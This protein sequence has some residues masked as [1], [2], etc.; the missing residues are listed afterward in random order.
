MR[1]K[2]SITVAGGGV[3]G[4]ACAA[5]LAQR[6]IPVLLITT[7][8]VQSLSSEEGYDA[9][10]YAL[11]LNSLALLEEIEVMPLVTRYTDF[12]ALEVWDAQSSGH[13]RF[14]AADIGS[15]RLGI[16]IEHRQLLSALQQRLKQLKIEPIGAQLKSATVSK[17]GSCVSL[18]LDNGQQLDTSL[19]IGADGFNSSV[20]TLMN[21][22]WQVQ[23]YRQTAFSCAAY[24]TTDHQMTGWQQFS[25]HGVVAFLPLAE[26]A[27]TIVWSCPA[28]L[29]SE[30]KLLAPP[31]LLQRV[32]SEISKHFENLSL[33]SPVAS[34]PLRGGQVDQYTKPGMVLIGD[35]AHSVHPLAGQGANLGFTDLSVLLNILDHSRLDYFNAAML[36]R[37]QRTVKGTNHLMKSGLEMLLW[38]FAND[39]A[40]SVSYVL[41]RV[42]AVG[43]NHLDT[44]PD[45]KKFFMK[46]AGSNAGN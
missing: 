13:I 34:F 25:K 6:N 38:L 46:Y 44:M 30:L 27:C 36:K 2:Q 16:V 17:Y 35:A 39:K 21:S 28:T 18:N 12:E 15:K 22:R 41:S 19:L 26:K 20:R 8:A 10:S 33:A 5:G 43:L 32:G 11:S 23:D 45:I 24:T 1:T 4:L 9:R 31:D 40:D 3:I 14:D 42:R 37:Y 7:D 29:A